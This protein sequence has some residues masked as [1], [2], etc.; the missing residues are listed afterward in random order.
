MGGGGNCKIIREINREKISLK[1]KLDLG[2]K[3]IILYK[4]LDQ[5]LLFEVWKLEDKPVIQLISKITCP[6]CSHYRLEQ[7]PVN[8]CQVFYECKEC[9]N[10]LKP[11]KGDCC[12]FC[13]YGDTPCPPIQQSREKGSEGG[14]CTNN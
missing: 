13:S 3:E 8:A 11:K 12:I 6:H 4:L 2:S 5:A 7:M 14:C 10:V 1:I 9:K